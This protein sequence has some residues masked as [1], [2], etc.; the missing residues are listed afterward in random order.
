MTDT[1]CAA[2]HP[3]D[4]TPCQGPHDAVTVSDRSGGSAEGCEHHAARLLASLEGG[5]LAP[6]SVEGAAI[7]VFETADRTRPYPWLTD[8]PRTEASQ[9]S[10]AEVRA[11]R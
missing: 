6:G 7:R 9:L 1:R 11:A 2:A 5:H 8:A 4:P 3:E 10:R